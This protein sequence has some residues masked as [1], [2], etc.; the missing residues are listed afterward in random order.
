MGYGV[1]EWGGGGWVPGSLSKVAMAGLVGT[2]SWPH[3]ALTWPR[4]SLADQEHGLLQAGGEQGE[5]RGWL[6]GTQAAGHP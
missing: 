6:S 2:M 5:G 4:A 1:L 3:Q